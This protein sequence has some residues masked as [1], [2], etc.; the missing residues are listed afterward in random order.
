[1]ALSPPVLE[2]GKEMY[3]KG[4]IIEVRCR[5]AR[6]PIPAHTP[7]LT[8]IIDGRQVGPNSVEPFVTQ[9]GIPGLTLALPASTV[10]GA[11]GRV[12]SECR[13]GLG[14]HQRSAHKTLRVR[15]RLISYIHTHRSAADT[16]TAMS[17]YLWVY[18]LPAALLQVIL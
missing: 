8:W 2:G 5:L 14:S 18:L 11:G 17:A 6:P 3:D 9:H 15:V 12:E 7:S 16:R 4:D 10:L 1:E 13:A